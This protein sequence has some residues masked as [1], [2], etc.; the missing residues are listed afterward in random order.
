MSCSF[1]EVS[2]PE[3]FRRISGSQD[4]WRFDPENLSRHAPDAHWLVLGSHDRPRGRCSLWWNRTPRYGQHRVGTIGHFAAAG[5]EAGR[6]LLSHACRELSNH[7]CTFAFGPMDGSTWR[8]YRFV[9]GKGSAPPFFLEPRHPPE[10]PDHF[11]RTG[12]TPLA[13]YLS[14]LNCDLS[15]DDRRGRECEQRFTDAG[16]RVREIDLE[17]FEDELRTIHAIAIRSFANNFLYTPIS[18]S[19]FVEHHLPFKPYLRPELIMVAE[20]EQR[21]VGFIFAVPDWLQLERDQDIDTVIIKTLA[22]LPGR[23]YA[24]LGSYLTRRNHNMVRELGYTRIIHAMMHSANSSRGISRRYAQPMR[25]YTL[26]GRPV[27]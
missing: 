3:D 9:T 8:S 21:G 23:K 4:L 13:R 17:R 2:S 10:W 19:E 27:R 22:I 7:D 24:G 15:Y 25:A 26:Y 11:T 14:S 1:V 12:F 18:E 20:Q 5:S 6:A 16:V